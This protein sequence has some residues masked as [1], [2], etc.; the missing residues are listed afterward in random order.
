MEI[1]G[2]HRMSLHNMEHFQFASHVIAMC[3]E[4]GIEKIKAVLDPLKTAVAEEDKAMIEQLVDRMNKV[5]IDIKGNQRQILASRKPK[6]PSKPKTPK[7]P[8]QPKEPKTP[9]Q[10]KEPKQPETPQP[11]KPGGEKPKDPKKPG[12]EDGNPDIHLPEE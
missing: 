6:D 1:K 8:K 5:V 12:G 2:I 3:E 10:P 11:P 7:E 4:S 9:D